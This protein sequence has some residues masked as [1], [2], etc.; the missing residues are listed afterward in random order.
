MT[1]PKIIITGKDGV[2][3]PFTD[4]LG[5]IMDRMFQRAQQTFI[6]SMQSA[7]APYSWWS[8][9]KP[10]TVADIEADMRRGWAALGGR[11]R[12][13]PAAQPSVTAMRPLYGA[14]AEPAG[15]GPMLDASPVQV[16]GKT[17][18]RT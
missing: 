18:Y 15:K 16:N 5:P 3:R 12:A 14:R 11:F 13:D 2:E 17:V 10:K 4:E 8:D 7:P 6:D 1:K 9:G